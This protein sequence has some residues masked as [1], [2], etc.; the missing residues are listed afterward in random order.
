M[1]K[2]LISLINYKTLE[3]FYHFDTV[4]NKIKGNSIYIN[5]FF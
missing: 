5:L 2:H 1:A 3:L 4:A